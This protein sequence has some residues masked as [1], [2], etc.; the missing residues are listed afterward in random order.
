MRSV[1]GEELLAG[2]TL[3]HLYHDIDV[4][5]ESILRMFIEK[6]PRRLFKTSVMGTNY[7]ASSYNYFLTTTPKK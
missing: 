6:Q 4:D 7:L 3:L 1:M 5:P 2:L